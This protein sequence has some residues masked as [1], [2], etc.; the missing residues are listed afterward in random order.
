MQYARSFHKY[1]KYLFDYMKRQNLLRKTDQCERSIRLKPD[2]TFETAKSRRHWSLI[3]L[4]SFSILY[5][6]KG[7]NE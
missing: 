1:T 3:S 6:L 4:C 2:R 5:Q 7:R